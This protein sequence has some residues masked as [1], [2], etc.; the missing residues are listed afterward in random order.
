[1]FLGEVE[2]RPME[3]GRLSKYGSLDMSV[4][5]HALLTADAEGHGLTHEVTGLMREH[6][7][8]TVWVI[9][10]TTKTRRGIEESSGNHLSHGI[11]V[12]GGSFPFPCRQPRR[13]YHQPGQGRQ[14]C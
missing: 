4:T 6:S 9:D 1:M 7:C 12:A 2:Q 3:R 5:F 8:M 11:P 14:G 10:W 13:I